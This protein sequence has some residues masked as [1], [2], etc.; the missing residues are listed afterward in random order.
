MCGLS[1]LGGPLK[2]QVNEQS[3]RLLP[4]MHGEGLSSNRV[5]SVVQDR[6]GYLWFATED[7]LNRYNG[8]EIKVFRH[9]PGDSTS[10]SSNSVSRM[11]VD[12]RGLL[13]VAA[14]GTG[15][16][17]YN[18]VTGKFKAYRPTPGAPHG[19]PTDQV[20][21]LLESRRGDIWIGADHGGGLLR[22]DPRRETFTA[23][24]LRPDT[25]RSVENRRH[26]AVLHL[27]E[28]PDEVLWL[29]T[30]D[31][32]YRFDPR[33]ET[34]TQY[35]DRPGSQDQY[36]ENLIISMHAEG[37]DTLWLGYWGG[38][39]KCFDKRTRRY[40]NT[41]RY[42][43]GPLS[44]YANLVPAILPKSASELWVSTH[45]N[46]LAVFN[47]RS[48][49]FDF[50]HRDPAD[51]HQV[52]SPQ[53]SY[54]Y[55]DRSGILWVASFDGVRYINPWAKAFESVKLP[56]AGVPSGRRVAAAYAH[57]NRLYVGAL[58]GAGL[59]V[60]DRQD[61]SWRTFP[62]TPGPHD[63]KDILRD[64]A[65]RW[66][67]STSAGVFGLDTLTHRFRRVFPPPGAPPAYQAVH[68]TCLLADRAGHLW[69]GTEVNGLFKYNPKDQSFAHYRPLADRP[70]SLAG[71]AVLALLEDRRGRVWAATSAGLSG[72][73]PAGDDFTN[74]THNPRDE[75]SLPAAQVSGLA[76]DDAG[77]LWAGTP[78]G[79]CKLSGLRTG[80]PTC[81]VYTV[82][83]GLPTNTLY[84]LTRDGAGR[85]WM[86]TAKGL[87]CV[88][89]RPATPRFGHFDKRDGLMQDYPNA[90]LTT[91]ATGHI[92]VGFAGSVTSFHPDSLLAGGLLPGR[93]APPVSLYSLKIFDKEARLDSAL[94][95]KT[96]VQLRGDENF[97]TI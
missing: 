61:G 82:A 53:T 77:N 43:P 67:V 9:V 93:P 45:D 41:Y 94:E 87:S 42:V 38:G 58:G 83:H 37:D 11:L 91:T 14:K 21:Y 65:G 23:Y 50:I 73:D 52:Y 7:G 96:R 63:V 27:V 40:L 39:L 49:R 36:Y 5:T 84:G 2:A 13:W 28:D 75:N 54:L 69:M 60:Y 35:L 56:A 22:F 72:Y 34:F 33:T 31:G 79:L 95:A 15:L 26:N 62:V 78:G 4:L 29:G 81:T 46:G 89:P 74:F 8:Q 68:F 48:G 90:E 71:F 86:G 24:Q 80:K 92:L 10:L 51:P 32:L 25:A 66:W 30:R 57:G 20:H 97:F 18:P 85:I 3:V 76:E 1:G 16:N 6:Q 12:R 55:Q 19:L 59:Y 44:G 88:D 47:K 64:P 70:R 17:C